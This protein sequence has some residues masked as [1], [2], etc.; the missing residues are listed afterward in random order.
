MQYLNIDSNNIKE[1]DFSL[2]NALVEINCSY[3]KIENLEIK[4]KPSL[5]YISCVFNNMQIFEI[6]NC[7]QLENIYCHNNKI[8]KLDLSSVEALKNF[9][10]NNSGLTE[11]KIKNG[12]NANLNFINIKNN[13]VL[14]CVE[15]ND[16]IWC[17]NYWIEKDLHTIYTQSCIIEP[18]QTYIPDI[19]FE[20]LLWLKN[21]DTGPFDHKVKTSNIDTITYL[22]AVN[23]S[24]KTMQGIED[25]ASL[26]VLDC[27]FNEIENLYLNQNQNLESLLCDFNQITSLYLNS[28]FK[29]K[30]LWCNNNNL[31]TLQIQNGNNRSF[32]ASDTFSQG[33][34]S[35]TFLAHNN[36]NLECIEVDDP[37]WSNVYWQSI[38]TQSFFTSFCPSDDR[39][40]HIPD[41]NFETKLIAL[42]LDEFP[43]DKAV[44]TSNIDTLK[45]LDVSFL[46]IKSLSGIEDFAALEELNCSRNEI[47][48]LILSKNENLIF[49]NCES[50]QLNFLDLKNGN[51]SNFIHYN[52]LQ[53]PSLSCI[54]VDN[55][56]W[57]Q[58]NWSFLDIESSFMEDIQDCAKKYEAS[59]PFKNEIYPNPT[60]STLFVISNEET[61]FSFYA[62]N[63]KN[64]LSGK[65]QIGIQ[66][67]Y[68]ESLESGVY[69]FT[70]INEGKRNIQK[71][72][73]Y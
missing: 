27:A 55:K 26:R 38:D 39:F 45:K 31:S 24:I 21:L 66:E 1:I 64:V 2:N 17:R 62:I 67:L 73:K 68:L 65:L 19:N 25:F 41:I 15:V 10:A 8:K 59:L 6:E 35:N 71:I 32:A 28:N 36:P 11:L 4:N 52:S 29:L 53:N 3:N 58:Q 33:Y 47:N 34:S 7:L 63:G 22:R 60:N 70:T 13:P 5:H 61:P 9:E 44:K 37:Y 46:A 20:Y 48:F 57:S 16:P 14:Y 49:L 43:T 23:R 72:V 50:N 42:G 51:N 69:Y 40:T 12:Q 54:F 18:G 30:E 56:I